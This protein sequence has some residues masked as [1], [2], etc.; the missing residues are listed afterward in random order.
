MRR[1][2]IHE[3]VL[4]VLCNVK[5]RQTFHLFKS[6]RNYLFFLNHQNVYSVIS[7][8]RSRTGL[9]KSDFK[10]EMTVSPKLTS[11]SFHYGKSFGTEEGPQG[12]LN[13]EVTVLVR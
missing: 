3:G 2:F 5:V 4:C 1:E 7:I 13:V 6:T 12:D 8:L 10:S 11:H 9:G